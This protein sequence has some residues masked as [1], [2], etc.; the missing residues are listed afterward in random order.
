MKSKLIAYILAA[1][2]IAVIAFTS[3]IQG[4]LTFIP[5]KPPYILL[6]GVALV[7][8]GIVLLMS[9]SSKKPKE[10]PIYEGKKVVG[11]RRMK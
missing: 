3:I 10:V 2:G 6:A 8:I 5:P 9:K 4:I 11:Y 1:I 7:I